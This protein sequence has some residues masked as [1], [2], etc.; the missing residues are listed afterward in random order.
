[1]REVARSRVL[2]R[3]QSLETAGQMRQQEMSR[4]GN[5][6]QLAFQEL[7]W[8]PPDQPEN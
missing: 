6:Q 5:F 4:V 7:G 8:G 2:S 3:E 1:M